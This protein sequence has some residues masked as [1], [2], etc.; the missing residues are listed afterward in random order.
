VLRV[1]SDILLVFHRGDFATLTLIDLSLA[2]DTVG[3]ET[4]PPPR[5]VWPVRRSTELVS[6]LH[7]R[8]CKH[9]RFAAT[10]SSA[11]T[12]LFGDPQGSVLGLS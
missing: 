6:V 3:R 10:K 8:S 12:V 5:L 7:T 11:S 4:P 2:F 1:T 9:A